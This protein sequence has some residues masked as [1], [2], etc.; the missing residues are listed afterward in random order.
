V[1]WVGELEWLLGHAAL[2]VE[3]APLAVEML[4]RLDARAIA[5]CTLTLQPGVSYLTAPCG[6]WMNW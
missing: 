6:R 3:R 1:R 4:T 5:D 2:E